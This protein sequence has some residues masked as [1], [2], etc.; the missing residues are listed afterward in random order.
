[1]TDE[2]KIDKWL[3]GDGKQEIEKALK[4]AAIENQEFVDSVRV[5]P[6]TLNEPTTI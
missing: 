1:M 3:S 5:D 2:E 6:K 4:Q